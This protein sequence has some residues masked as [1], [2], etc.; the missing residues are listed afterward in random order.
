MSQWLVIALKEIRD[1]IRDKRALFFAIVYGPLFMPLMI[2]GPML[3]GVKSKIIDFEATTPFHVVG[4]EYAPN[5]IAFL[6][7]KNLEAQ[8]AP[9]NFQQLVREGELD[10]VVE[11]PP[12]YAELFREGHR[13]PITLYVNHSNKESEKAARQ[14]R[15]LISNYSYHM[16]YWRLRVRGIDGDMNQAFNIVEQDLSSEGFSGMVFGFF[17]YFV[18]VFTMMMGGF[19]LAIDITAGERERN[20]LEPLLGLP[21]PRVSIVLGKYLAIFCFV[22]VS[23]LLSV[24]SLYLLFKFLPF[25]E[26][27]MFLNISGLSLSRSFLLALPLCFLICSVLMATAAFTKS[28]KEAQTY[29]SILYL[30]PMA[31]LLIGQF[32]NI[33]TTLATM[34]IPFYSQYVLI[35]KTVKN[36]TVEWLHVMAASGGALVLALLF[37]LVAVGL[38][39]QEKILAN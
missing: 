14:L 4:V 26:L 19:Y 1:N 21:V 31:P 32:A 7:A 6:K 15:T 30:I 13:I 29:I 28:A 18:I 3:L 35:D 12:T 25:D 22:F 37:F 20:S 8:E 36:E 16:G 34:L 27:S 39:R 33:K 9:A 5:F 23:G 38:Y 24:I 10:A 2:V 17:M 11:I